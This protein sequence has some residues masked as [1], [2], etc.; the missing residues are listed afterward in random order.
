MLAY[1]L[2]CTCTIRPINQQHKDHHQMS[3]S[4]SGCSL[5]RNATNIFTK[6]CTR[7]SSTNGQIP[8]PLVIS[9]S[10]NSTSQSYQSK[11]GGVAGPRDL[12][13]RILPPKNFFF[14]SILRHRFTAITRFCESLLKIS[15]RFSEWEA[16]VL[17]AWC[18]FMSSLK[19]VLVSCF[20]ITLVR[21]LAKKGHVFIDLL[22]V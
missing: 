20:A 5:S 11:W 2:A 16:V 18:V 10:I 15:S 9:A 17:I 7:W 19:S 13:R 1:L 8:A 22:L 3:K 12:R 21:L 4:S 6:R 14:S